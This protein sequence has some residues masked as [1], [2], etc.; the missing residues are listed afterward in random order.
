[1]EKLVRDGKPPYPR[2]WADLYQLD[3]NSEVALDGL[4]RLAA[5]S[6]DT[7]N[8]EPWGWDVLCAHVLLIRAGRNADAHHRFLSAVLQD[9]N[10]RTASWAVGS[11]MSLDPGNPARSN[12]VERCFKFFDSGRDEG[13]V[14]YAAQGFSQ[15]GP[16]D[17]EYVPRLI[18]IISQ[19]PTK[20]RLRAVCS[21]IGAL[22]NIGPG[23]RRAVP[24][25]QAITDGKIQAPEDWED[26]PLAYR[27]ETRYQK[28]AAD[29]LEKIRG[30]EGK[31]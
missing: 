15:F 9:T 22:G 2:F 23:A 12:A 8:I 27:S 19:P 24:Q 26:T 14:V 5:T 13:A 31:P 30:G 17:K 20:E 21:A 3:S 7:Q 28:A 6:P 18:Q 29:A 10:E 16:Q 4:E 25:L 1:L 11:I